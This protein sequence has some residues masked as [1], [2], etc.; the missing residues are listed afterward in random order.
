[1]LSVFYI[2][3]STMAIPGVLLT[4]KLGAKWTIPGYMMGW[5][6]MA[7]INAGCTNFGGV[8]AVRLCE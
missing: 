5:G 8:V 4:R 3:F 2:T 1:M 7:T 6:A